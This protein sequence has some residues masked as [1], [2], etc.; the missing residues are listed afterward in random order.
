MMKYYTF[1]IVFFYYKDFIFIVFTLFYFYYKI[2]S[3]L[4][5]LMFDIAMESSKDVLFRRALLYWLKQSYNAILYWSLL[6]YSLTTISILFLFQLLLK[7]QQLFLSFIISII[8]TSLI[9]WLNKKLDRKQVN[10]YT[11]T[12]MCGCSILPK[13]I[14]ELS[15]SYCPALLLITSVFG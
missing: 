14:T 7:Y 6:Y 8:N 12:I 3:F 15:L 13:W 5:N 4:T 1:I 11:N 2:A 10:L 9:D